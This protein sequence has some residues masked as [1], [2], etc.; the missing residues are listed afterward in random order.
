[1][2]SAHPVVN[3]VHV[4]RYGQRFGTTGAAPELW[5]T[6]LYSDLVVL[7]PPAAFPSD[8]ERASELLHAYAAGAV[9]DLNQ[10]ARGKP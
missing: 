10:S 2:K 5:G 4:Q 1:L 6:S 7:G 9:K 8:P 3:R